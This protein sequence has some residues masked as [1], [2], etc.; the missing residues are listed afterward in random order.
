MDWPPYKINSKTKIQPYLTLASGHC[1]IML[2]GAHL[3]DIDVVIWK[4]K[5]KAD[6]FQDEVGIVNS[7]EIKI[8]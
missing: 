6:P 3:L 4:C 8:W 7:S 5:Y 2:E 1:I